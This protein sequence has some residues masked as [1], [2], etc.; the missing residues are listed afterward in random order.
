MKKTCAN[1]HYYHHPQT[2]PPCYDCF[3]PGRV[4]ERP[5]W[6]PQLCEFCQ[7]REAWA[8]MD[9]VLICGPCWNDKM[10]QVAWQNYQEVLG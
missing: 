8:N 9:G 5:N 4:D 2:Y 3:V 7:L 6:R 10:Q 1:C